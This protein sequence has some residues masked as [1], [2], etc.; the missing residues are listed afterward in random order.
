[1]LLD[2]QIVK[3]VLYLLHF[4]GELKYLVDLPHLLL[5]IPELCRLG[6]LDD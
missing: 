1:M 5:Q 2:L 6:L 4:V 3:V